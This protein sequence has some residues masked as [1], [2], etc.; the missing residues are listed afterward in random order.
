[1]AEVRKRK[2]Q[3]EIGFKRQVIQEIDSGSITLSAAARKYEVSPGL[4]NLWRDKLSCGGLT[5]APSKR[6]RE[7]EKDLERYKVLL[8]E[9]HAEREFLKKAQSATL[10]TRKLVTAVISGQNLAQF[11]KDSE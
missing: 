2:R 4:I 7:L 11:R 5:E 10:R 8:A 3:F 9:A 1:M 6:E